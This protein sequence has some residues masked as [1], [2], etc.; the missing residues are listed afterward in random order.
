MLISTYS[1]VTQKTDYEY[2]SA[3][4]RVEMTPGFEEGLVKP[5]EKQLTMEF[6]FNKPKEL[7]GFGNSGKLEKLGSFS[8]Y[9]VT[10]IELEIKSK[11]VDQHL[12][13]LGYREKLSDPEEIQQ[14]VKDFLK[15][16]T[17][18]IE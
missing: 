12:I 10:R 16:A 9:G 15:Q 6:K 1:G 7:T 3:T 4:L 5:T 17:E 14:T 8:E 13:T 2:F 18:L 11:V